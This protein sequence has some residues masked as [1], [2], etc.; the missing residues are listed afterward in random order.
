[1]VPMAKTKMPAFILLFAAFPSLPA[2]GAAAEAAAVEDGDTLSLRVVIQIPK[3]IKA[4]ALNPTTRWPNVGQSPK[5]RAPTT[6]LAVSCIP[7][8]IGIPPDTPM[9]SNERYC[10]ICAPA[11]IAPE[12]KHHQKFAVVISGCAMR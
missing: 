10:N 3:M 12:R 2:E 5:K 6:E 1:M 9:S 7:V 4:M 11:H 8:E